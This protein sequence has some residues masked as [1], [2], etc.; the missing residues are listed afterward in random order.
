MPLLR[1]LRCLRHPL[2]PRF[3]STPSPTPTGAPPLLLKLRS[4]LKSALKARDAPRLAVLRSLLAEVTNQSKTAS[5][6]Q[7]DM[8]LLSLLR[9][10][11][12]SAETAKQEFEKAGRGDLVEKEVEQEGILGEYVG[13]VETVSAEEVKAMV[14]K[15]VGRMM[16]EGKG[17]FKAGLVMKEMLKKDGVF[18]GKNVEKVVVARAVKDVLAGE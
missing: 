6:L 15:E 1:P 2:L 11:Q 13:S 16:A 10:R 17:E 5:P 18:E 9:K 4:D 3:Y 7:T 14:T 12:A 8:Q